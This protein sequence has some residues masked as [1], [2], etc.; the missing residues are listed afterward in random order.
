MKS[1]NDNNQKVP[2]PPP[3]QNTQRD[4]EGE[5]LKKEGELTMS[6]IG[7]VKEQT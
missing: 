3:G 5:H 2:Q 1:I 7:S 6:K 4:R